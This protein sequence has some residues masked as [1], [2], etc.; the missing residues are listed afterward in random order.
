MCLRRLFAVA[1]LMVFA[2]GALS[3]PIELS[4]MT[5][6]QKRRAMLPNIRAAT[7]CVARETLNH[8]SIVFS[9]RFNNIEGVI[10][11]AWKQCVA[12]LQLIVAQHD[13]LHGAGSGMAFVTGPYRNDLARAVLA[14]IRPEL[15]RRVLAQDQAEAAERAAKAQQDIDRRDNIERLNRTA[16]TI[17]DLFYDCAT[18]QL[19]KLVRSAEA[20]DVLA[21]AAMTICRK[22][23]ND[24]FEAWA[25]VGRADGSMGSEAS[26]REQLLKV[27][28]ESVV[29]TAVQLK[30]GVVATGQPRPAATPSE[31]NGLQ[32]CLA[33]MA[34]AREGKFINQKALLEGM[35]ELCRPEI[36]TVAR[37]AFLSV[38]NAD[39]ASERQKALSQA[40][41][42]ARKILGMFD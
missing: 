29:T 22:E 33:T 20:A 13:G 31:P 19:E 24:A 16:R 11:D 21:T 10:A 40:S 38:P 23:M 39:L 36:E 18:Q 30:A 37:A 4:P 2:G 32:N 25:A 34:K 8:Q 1:G 35:L 9:Y 41:A 15:D 12:E 28:R 42:A 14:R 6:A 26:L 5:D 3:Q 7:D 27:T 17:R